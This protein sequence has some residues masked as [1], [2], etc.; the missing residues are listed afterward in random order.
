[1]SNGTAL[2]F[3]NGR[4][5]WVIPLALGV[6][7][8]FAPALGANQTLMRQIMVIALLAL[9]VSGLNL[10][11]GFGG[12]L[13]V[14]QIVNYALGAYLTGWMAINGHD[15]AVSILVSI[16][17]A[18]LL[19]LIVALPS[20]RVGGWGLAMASFFLVILIPSTVNLWPK[21]TGGLN[22]LLGI[23]GP[24]L[25]GIKLTPAQFYVTVILCTVV[26]FALMRN[27]VTSRHG[28]AL[29]VVRESPV[30]A[31][32]LG[33]SVPR[34]KATA[35][36]LGAIPAGLAGSLFVYVDRFIAPEN[37]SFAAAILL[38]AASVIGGLESVYGAIFGAAVLTY[39][40]AR[41][42]SFGEYADI[43]FGCFLI[44]GGI[45]LTDQRVK[46]AIATTRRRFLGWRVPPSKSVGVGGHFPALNGPHLTAAGISKN[47]GGN[48]AL[49]DVS[50]VA[51]PGEITA[52]IGANGSGKTTLLNIMSGFYKAD[53]GA[54]SLDGST[55][56]S[57]RPVGTARR[58]IARTFQTP[59]VPQS[60]SALEAVAVARYNSD[61]LG[62]FPAMIRLP[63]YWR[64]RRR[65]REEA[66]QWL[67]S[68]G[69]SGEQDHLASSL[70]LGSR[71]LL[72]VARALSTGSAALLLD[73][74]ASGL[75]PSDVET[76]A[77]LL[78]KLKEAG[79]TIVLVE[80]NFNLVCDIA[81]SIFVLEQGRL[82]AQ[83]SP[84][85]IRSNEAVARSYLG[86]EFH[87]ELG[88]P[89]DDKAME[90]VND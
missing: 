51:K 10:A 85:Q 35:Y 68:V 74:P 49:R 8:L 50:V 76:F 39:G 12:E 29:K 70:P 64:V 7:L 30:L 86:H 55:L 24:V 11:W 80:H 59:L 6:L 83:G 21:E 79:A 1:M 22:G 56:P 14:G 71:R 40:S 45:L 46:S 52:L 54:V 17:A 3:V 33:L 72:E 87:G 53:A 66:G 42:G 61:K 34:L 58:G 47:F 62:I 18:S 32:A 43:V 37:F 75:D 44:L 26:W 60:T 84:D 67:T 15:M 27:L 41:I 77:S 36:V 78:L 89:A 69:L 4:T 65:D 88:G 23:P 31:S 5:L 20:V 81:D 82:I 38:I 63:K 16:L 9:P 90:V 19:G 73:E 57:G 25:F 48:P 2:R 13:A 28:S